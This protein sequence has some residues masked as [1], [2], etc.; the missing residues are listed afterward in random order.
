MKLSCIKAIARK[1]AVQ[2]VRNRLLLLAL[3]SGVLFSA[4][5]YVLPSTV[6]ETF[7]LAV[8]GDSQ[9]IG[10][11]SD[12]EEEGIEV[13]FFASEEEVKSAVRGGDYI[14]GVVYP[15]D[16]VSQLMSGHKPHIIL[17]F[18]SD[19]PENV[20]TAIEY[21]MQ[22]AI[23]YAVSGEEPLIVEEEI[24]GEDMAGRHIPLN[25]RSIPMY[26][27]M[28]LIMEMWTISTLIVEESAAGTLR[29]VLVTPASPSDV[30]MAKGLVGISYSLSV[31]FAILILTWSLRGNLPVLFLGILL[32]GVMAVSL[33]LFTGSLTEN[34]V[35]SYV[36]A[37]LPM[38]VFLIPALLIFLPGASLS[39]VKVIPTYYMVHAF[40]QI[41]NYGAGLA[42]VW[43]D[44]L[45]IAV[46]DGIFFM[47][48]IYALRRRYS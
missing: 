3:L 14:V 21:L 37:G 10:D 32:G 29:A 17:Y 1:D 12:L 46:C 39:V 11:I 13:G 2:A 25:E 15:E 8:S 47:L 48:G 7:S 20:R 26:V 5:Y 31:A 44:F 24:L 40:D 16:F 18:K 19:Q 43:K 30:I 41:L 4:V 9:L 6:E 42:E 38:L 33:G 45:V 35:G 28:A 22:L 36:Y 23:E 27:L 34:I